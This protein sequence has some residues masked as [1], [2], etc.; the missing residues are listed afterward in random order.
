MSINWKVG[1]ETTCS[2][3]NTSRGRIFYV[4]SH[5]AEF[6]LRTMKGSFIT[7]VEMGCYSAGLDFGTYE[8]IES[9]ILALLRGLS[10]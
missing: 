9:L 7:L 10:E 6:D 2:T 1:P 4:I 3:L 5:E 8:D